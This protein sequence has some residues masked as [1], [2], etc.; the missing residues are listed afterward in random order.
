[1]TQT[2]FLACIM[3]IP[4]VYFTAFSFGSPGFVNL[5]SPVEAA[6]LHSG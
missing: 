3:N 6:S 2:P 1:M 5:A 4:L